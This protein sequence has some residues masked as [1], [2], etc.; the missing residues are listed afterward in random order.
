MGRDLLAGRCSRRQRPIFR[1][2]PAQT[3]ETVALEQIPQGGHV[4]ARLV[5]VEIA[6]DELVVVQRLG[7]LDRAYAQRVGGRE[8]G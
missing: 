6:I 7:Q 3:P 1:L 5:D 8:L 4:I 2:H